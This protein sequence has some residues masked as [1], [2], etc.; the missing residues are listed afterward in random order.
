MWAWLD[1]TGPRFIRL[2]TRAVG[3]AIED[4]DAYINAGRRA[5]TSDDGTNLGLT[6]AAPASQ[7]PPAAPLVATLTSQPLDRPSPRRRGKRTKRGAHP[8][9]TP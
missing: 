1:G 3:Y 5:S 8:M 6:A 9:V 4:L 2:G 7:E